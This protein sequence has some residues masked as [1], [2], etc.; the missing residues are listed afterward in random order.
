MPVE[1]TAL[2]ACTILQNIRS[3]AKLCA[4]TV[5]LYVHVNG[6]YISVRDTIAD[7]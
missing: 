1:N 7:L 6:R 4:F 5:A 2:S 3:S